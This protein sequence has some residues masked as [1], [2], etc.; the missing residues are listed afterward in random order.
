[1]KLPE[2][3]KRLNED[4]NK[5]NWDAALRRMR[6]DKA[7]YYKV[8]YIKKISSDKDLLDKSYVIIYDKD[9]KPLYK[10]PPYIKIGKKIE[11][12]LYAIRDLVRL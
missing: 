6:K 7:M 9:K 12:N 1:M 3:I 11:G 8:I 5:G 4:P 10:I 2:E